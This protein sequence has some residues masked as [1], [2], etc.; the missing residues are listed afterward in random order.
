MRIFPF[1]V[2]AVL[3]VSFVFP[4]IA[5]AQTSSITG[6]VK[7]TSGAV[8]PGVSIEVSS[9]ALI[10]KARSAVSDESGRYRVI[11]LRPG[12]Y[13]VAFSLPGFSTVKRDDIE[14]TSNFTA[15]VNAELMVGNVQDSVTVTEEV[16]TVDTQNITTRTVMTR[17]VL[18]VLPTGRNIQAV[19][20]MIPGTGLSVGGG[21]ALSRDVGGSGG[22][23]QSPLTYRGSADTVQTIDGIRLNNLCANGA[24]SGVYWNDASLQE[25]S[26]VTGADSASMAQGGVRVAM[27]PKEGGNNFHGS[28]T[29]NFTHGPWQTGN[30]RSNLQGDL[31]TNKNNF[32]TNVSVIKKI[33]DFNPGFGGPIVKDKLWFY[34]TF[35]HQGVTKTVAD[36]YFNKLG[37]TSLKYEADLG[38]PAIDD[39]HIVSRAGRLSWQIGPRDKVTIYHDWQAKYRNHWGVSATIAPEAS[40][41]QVTPT[42]FVHVDKWTRTQSPRLVLDA[43]FGI[44][45]QEYTELYQP[46]VV[47]NNVKVF[48]PALIAKSTIYSVT[49][50]TTS[51]VTGAWNNPADH[52]SV[53]RTY[54]GSAS[55]V[56][57]GHVLNV[58]STFSEGTRRLV[59]QYTGDLTMTFSQGLPQSV[60][61]RTPLD[62]RDGIK[63][64]FG[65]FAQ[66][67]WTIKRV[68]LNLGLRY[69]WFRGQVLDEELPASR[70][71]PATHFDGFQVQ[72]WKDISPRFGFAIDLFGNGKTAVRTSF[73]RYVNGEGVGTVVQNN[74]ETT[75][76]RTDT[77]TWRDL[78]TDFTIFNSDGSV[79]TAEL[80]ATTNV[81]FGKVVPS[82]TTSDPSILNGWGKRPYNWEYQLSFQHEL[83]SGLSLNWAY[84]RRSFANQIIIDNQF[85]DKSS[86]DGPF[87]IT[88]PS[89]P[90]LPGGGGFQVCDLYDIKP[91]FQ[92]QV[93]NIRKLAG[94]AG[95]VTDVFQGFD[96]SLVGRFA[97]RTFIQGGINAQKRD[98]NDCNSPTL[99]G[100]R[101]IDSPEARFCDQTFPYRPDFKLS[102]SHNFPWNVILSG[103]YQFSQGPN[104]LATWAV[105]NSIIAPALG[106]NLSAGS[107]ATKTVSLVEPGTLYGE[108]L[109]Q[110]DLRASKRFAW[111]SVR[112]RVDL[113]LYNVFNSNWPFSLNNTFSTAA[114]SQWM[115]PTN[116]LQG[117]LFKMGAQFDF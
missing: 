38:R 39:G 9:P 26:Y 40:A 102:G 100:N 5:S 6:I 44:Y 105:P 99:A 2:I 30:L 60:T 104:K 16:A 55:Y 48:D 79:Q 11:E 24:Y 96:V 113:D 103:T 10:E 50:Q 49:E 109:N 73:A 90:N 33:W 34:A 53:L 23:Q 52:F 68:T 83:V 13:S 74:P 108:N 114:T 42:S 14:I 51:K 110:L 7:D 75:I 54:S 61:L 112:F 78:N 22:L 116:V 41:I 93:Q 101:N 28:V 19:G 63:G 115:R 67:K 66:E 89:N 56:T 82:T 71:N 36:S 17:D 45:N 81:N 35:R 64:D 87:C 91:T 3:A 70:W 84:Y 59:E 65:F 15:N 92:G 85:T 95:G 20:I 12:K 76:G 18:D 58:G 37:E 57:G 43:G 94:A 86:Y 1:R 4:V 80:G 27:A 29:G 47:G 111:E 69:D 8:L 25:I 21:G 46:S 117:R 88:A 106:R 97:R 77:R 62:Q 98:L 107:T 31:T 32:L 72:N